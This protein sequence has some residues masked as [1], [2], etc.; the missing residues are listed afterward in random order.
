MFAMP[1]PRLVF[2]FSGHLIDAPDRAQPRFPLAQEPVAA[3][4]I[5]AA[6]DDCGASADDLA[7]TQGAAGGDL[8]FC[9]AALQRGLRV[10]LLQPFREAEFLLRSVHPCPGN[11]GARYA[12][13]AARLAEPPRAVQD[14]RGPLA[15]EASPYE[16]CNLWLLDEAL[17][18]GAARLRFICLWNGGGG[19]GP[20]GT[21]HMVE[22]VRRAGGQVSW[23]DT[24]ELFRI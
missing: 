10:Q 15:P 4:A 11:W 8:Q 6:L 3:A 7:L 23:L 1:T 5:A 17:S 12:A 14:V 22:A 18:Y 9:E 2:L 19:D 20:G 13:V 24:R 21:A 16:A